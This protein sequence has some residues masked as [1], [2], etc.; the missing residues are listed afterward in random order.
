[1]LDALARTHPTEDADLTHV[2]R[3]PLAL[4]ITA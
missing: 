2:Q 1:M 3:D 4:V